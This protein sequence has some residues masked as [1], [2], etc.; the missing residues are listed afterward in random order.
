MVVSVAK[1]VF[2]STLLLA[3][4][5][6]GCLGGTPA[7][8]EALAAPDL[9]TLPTT[10][11]PV[12][13]HDRE[14]TA[15]DVPRPTATTLPRTSAPAPAAAT[16]DT[17]PPF[18]PADS[19]SSI[20]GT[21]AATISW[22][23]R[24]A[25]LVKSYVEYGPT[26]QFGT[27][28]PIVA[29]TGSVHVDLSALQPEKTYYFRICSSDEL[30]HVSCTPTGMFAT[31]HSSDSQ[32][33]RVRNHS[34]ELAPTSV[35]IKWFVEEETADV[36]TNLVWGINPEQLQA[37]ATRLGKGAHEQTLSGLQPETR[38]YW[39]I[40]VMDGAG[41]PGGIA[42]T[43]FTTPPLPD[44]EIPS[45]LGIHLATSTT[46]TARINWTLADDKP[47]AE[48]RIEYHRD[49]AAEPFGTKLGFD[50]GLGERSALL[51][52]LTPGALY[53]YRIR[54]RDDA[55]HEVVSANQTF[56]TQA[57]ALATVYDDTVKPKEIYPTGLVI[58]FQFSGPEG[59]T[60]QIVYGKV[61]SPM[62]KQTPLTFVTPAAR[63][64]AELTLIEIEPESRYA[65]QVIVE[66]PA[67]NTFT[68]S[69][70]E[71]W[72]AYDMSYDI[73]GNLGPNSYA[74]KDGTG[75]KTVLAHR[76][77]AFKVS[78]KDTVSHGFYLYQ[79]N[80]NY[81]AAANETKILKPHVE[82][83]PGTYS[84]ICLEPGH[85]AMRATLNVVLPP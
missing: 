53:H 34:L 58:K 36:E 75:P 3:M 56:T 32:A 83:E 22:I 1:S 18:I 66:D 39:R 60:A 84:I 13:P 31:A 2:A 28:S 72:S 79:S 64:F 77:L 50:E 51:G 6:A 81:R 5:L 25:S 20:V 9:T 30:A 10:D 54:A 59:T 29:G 68:S 27:K 76:P 21:G 4:A 49:G 63:T 38:Y 23:V 8:P 41:N 12:D 69:V 15:D 82:L 48:S 17:D 16:P 7:D 33:P 42:T 85:G 65:Y 24:D 14:D 11:A 37:T 73:I 80:T 45:I 67:G 19:I 74:H 44:T 62:D 26:Q 52:P 57:E 47:T 70:H 46:T 35:H 61:G 78:N 55:G 71:T 40:F 43:T